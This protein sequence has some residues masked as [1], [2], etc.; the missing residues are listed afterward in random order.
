M[1]LKTFLLREYRFNAAVH[2]QMFDAVTHDLTEDELNWQ[3]RPGHHSIWHHIWHMWLSNDY[4]F[5]GSLQVQPSWEEGGWQERLDLAP[6]ARAFDYPGNALGGMVP[7]FVIADVPDDLVDSLK[8][9]PLSGFV[10]YV[11]DFIT[12]STE[13]LERASDPQLKR[14]VDLYGHAEIPAF[15][16]A[17]S[18]SHVARH[19][20]MIEDVRGLLRG[21]GKGTASI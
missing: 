1:D 11:D 13:M 2:R 4:Y 8:A 20:G 7:R 5:A 12:R 6:M 21:P 3:A 14:R 19:I 17:T 18:F 15:V 9:L 16:Q 10:A